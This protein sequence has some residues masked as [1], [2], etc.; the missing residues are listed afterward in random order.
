MM[1]D[2]Y[3]HGGILAKSFSV[4][5]MW[6]PDILPFH[7]SLITQLKMMTAEDREGILLALGQRHSL[8]RIRLR[9]PCSMLQKFIITI[10]E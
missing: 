4:W 9:M 5:G 8:V 1:S 7:S 3:I 10:D 2:Y 6:G